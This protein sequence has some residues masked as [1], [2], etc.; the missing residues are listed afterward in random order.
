MI[1]GIDASNLRSGGGITHLTELLSFADPPSLG[2]AKVIV[3]AP[4][5]TL[6]RLPKRPWLDRRAVPSR[7]LGI[8]SWLNWQIRGLSVCARR[9]NCS[10]L[11]VPGGTYLGT[12]RPFVTMSRNMLP[13]ERREIARYPIGVTRLRFWVL[14]QLQSMTFR[15]ADGLIFLT[16]YAKETVLNKIGPVQRE[17]V[18]IPHG[19]SPVFRVDGR[20]FREISQCSQDDPFRIVYVS[21]LSHY[22][23]QC[24]VIEAV[25]EVRRRTSW[26]LVLD[27]VGGHPMP[28]YYKAFL[29]TQRQCDPDGSWIRYHGA[30][31]YSDL[32]NFLAAGELAVFASS[33]ENMPNTL[34]EKMLSG[35]P[36]V[37]SDRGPMPECIGDA[38]RLFDP[39]NVSEIAAA[40]EA[41]VGNVDER[42]RLASMAKAR[43][44]RFSWR[45]CA[46][47]TF[48]FLIGIHARYH[49]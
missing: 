34:L 39:E 15:H 43:A 42:E 8:L 48:R 49:G 36:I 41:L 9:A 33:C 6:H 4:M 11:F 5:S 14:R 10:V 31:P 12:F 19:V 28:S 13:F 1:V 20:R 25:A 45:R 40:V 22:K 26:P 32:R 37:C 38:G 29:A 3:W 47:E 30:Q 21:H 17:V 23:H 27:L 35:I 7:S 46:E 18:T 2:V 44:S 16:N 24:K